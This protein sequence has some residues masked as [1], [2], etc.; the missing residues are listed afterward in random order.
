M[1]FLTKTYEYLY[2]LYF[3]ILLNKTHPSKLLAI[4][5]PA[6]IVSIISYSSNMEMEYK[7]KNVDNKCS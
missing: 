1:E 7:T 6:T 5:K 2:W 4:S 3:I